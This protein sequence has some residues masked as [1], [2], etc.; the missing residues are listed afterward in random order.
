M[1]SRSEWGSYK[2][3]RLSIDKSDWQKRKEVVDIELEDKSEGEAIEALK[4]KLIN[5]NPNVIN[6]KIRSISRK[7]PANIDSSDAKIDMPL[8]AVPETEPA[9]RP[10]QMK[11]AAWHPPP[12][13]G[14]AGR[15]GR[16]GSPPSQPITGNSSP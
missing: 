7:R 9:K 3:A 12:A 8:S 16:E 6:N 4:R 5:V 15:T 13:G 11:A 2:V 14:A 1:N 10:K